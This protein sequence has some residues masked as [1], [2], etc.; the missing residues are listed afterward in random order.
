[1]MAGV[2]SVGRGQFGAGKFAIPVRI[3]ADEN[4]RNLGVCFGL[5]DGK[6]LV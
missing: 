3:K 5:I 6:R 1:M 2:S 4:L